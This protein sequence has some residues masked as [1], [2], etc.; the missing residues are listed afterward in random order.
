MT[1][2][3]LSVPPRAWTTLASLATRDIGGT[4]PTLFGIQITDDNMVVYPGASE[5]VLASPRYMPVSLESSCCTKA[6]GCG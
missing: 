2:S 4:P 1:T 3:L 5:L 6:V